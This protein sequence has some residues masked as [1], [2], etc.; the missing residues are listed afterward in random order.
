MI[1]PL[2]TTKTYNTTPIFS[3]KGRSVCRLKLEQNSL[4]FSEYWFPWHLYTGNTHRTVESLRQTN[5]K[6]HQ[7]SFHRKGSNCWYMALRE[8]PKKAAANVTLRSGFVSNGREVV[9]K[10]IV[11]HDT[12]RVDVCVKLRSPEMERV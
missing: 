5:F 9:F 2:D 10:F 3:H 11:P 4:L 6:K 7:R 12:V 8:N 1:L